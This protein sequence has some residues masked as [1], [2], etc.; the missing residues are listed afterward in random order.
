MPCAHSASTLWWRKTGSRLRPLSTCQP[1]SRDPFGRPLATASLCSRLAASL[2]TRAG[3]RLNG[4]HPALVRSEAANLE[5]SDAVAKG[6][7]KGSR[8][9]G[10]HVDNGLKRDPV[11]RHQRVDAE[12]AQGMLHVAAHSHEPGCM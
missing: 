10:W 11:L 12:W 4:R 1:P 7:P 8:L 2:L 9:G 6:L 5:H 3:C